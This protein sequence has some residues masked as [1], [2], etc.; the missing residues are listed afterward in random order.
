MTQGNWYIIK[1]IE[2]LDTPGL[3]IYPQRVRENINILKRMIDDVSRLRPHVKTHKSK[4]AALLMLDAGITKFKCATIAEAEM[5]G[6]AN[7]PDVLLAYQPVGPKLERFIELN[8]I[9]PA[10]KFSCLVDNSISAQ[11]ISDTALKNHLKINVYLDLN[12]GMNRT[13]I[14]PGLEALQLYIDCNAL[15]GI[16]L[17]GLHAYDGHIHDADLAVRTKRCNESFEPVKK[18]QQSIK[19]KGYPEPIII[20]GGSPTF[21]IHLKRKVVECSPGTFIY[22]DRGYS[23][24]CAEQPFLTAALVVSR[25][26][27]LPDETK[28]CLDAGHKSISAENELNKRIYFLN[29]P[30]LVFIGQSEEHLVVDAGKDHHYK[31]GDVFYGLPYHVC[32]TIA[33]YERAITIEDYKISGEWRNIARDRKINI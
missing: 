17:I 27:S 31:V 11:S 20:A 19:E 32:P 3:V 5:L 18:L 2:K 21:P 15:P 4:E 29:A 16:K 13:G 23:L 33:L 14:T 12:V 7:A 8:K 9:Y 28:L 26:I 25:V 1:D 24:T 6:M 22:W 30:E 10:T